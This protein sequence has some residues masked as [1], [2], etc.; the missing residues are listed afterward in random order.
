M[1]SLISDHRCE[2]TPKPVRYAKT[3]EDFPVR[4]QE[5]APGVTDEPSWS[6]VDAAREKNE[7]RVEH[8]MPDEPDGDFA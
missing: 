6:E 2:S 8:T 3:R 5:P 1:N 7:R 4:P